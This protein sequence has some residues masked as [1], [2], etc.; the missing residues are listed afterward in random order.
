MQLLSV[1]C[2]LP[3]LSAILIACSLGMVA[4]AEE[5]DP[6]VSIQ[7]SRHEVRAGDA[8]KIWESYAIPAGYGVVSVQYEGEMLAFFHRNQKKNIYL[9]DTFGRTVVPGFIEGVPRAIAAPH[10]LPLR[11]RDDG[12]LVRSETL[13]V[14]V[15]G[16]YLLS[17]R[18]TLRDR[19]GNSLKLASKNST[20]LFVAPGAEIASELANKRW[21]QLEEMSGHAN[22]TSE[23]GL[24]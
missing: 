2:F 9:D 21:K 6:A 1:V 8:V 20:I 14:K 22:G 4:N 16:I 11:R 10:G 17:A 7:L 3:C 15:P 24:P 23:D 13:E 12:C 5:K 18:F 19:D